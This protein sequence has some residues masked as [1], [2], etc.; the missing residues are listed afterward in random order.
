MARILR[1]YKNHVIKAKYIEKIHMIKF[2]R[3]K[4]NVPFLYPLK[5][6]ENLSQSAFTYS[7]LI[8]ETLEQGV[9]YV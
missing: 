7:K 9:K 1:F 2:N 5:T 8:I 4:P 3:C 6:S